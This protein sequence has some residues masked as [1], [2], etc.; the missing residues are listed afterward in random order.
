MPSDIP[1][2]RIAL[3][4][5]AD[6]INLWI[7]NERSVTSLHKDNYENMYA[8][9]RGQKHFVLLPPIELPC[10][11]EQSLPQA[12]YTVD[13]HQANGEFTLKVHDSSDQEMLPVPIWDPDVPEQRTTMYSHLSHPLRVT[14]NEGDM[15]YMPAMWYHKVSQTAGKEGF[16]CSVNFWYDMEFSGSFWTSTELMRDL[17]DERNR[18]IQYPELELGD[19]G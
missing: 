14:L 1:S 3:D 17:V 5:E 7:G 15:L 11:N 2:A 6:A 13:K 18:A 19:E 9:I 10:V 8:Q 16:A 4:K 12:W